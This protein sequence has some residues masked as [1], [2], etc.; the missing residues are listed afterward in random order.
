MGVAGGGLTRHHLSHKHHILSFSGEFSFPEE[1]WANVSNDA[2]YLL[3]KL[4]V[5]DPSKRFT[6]SEAMRS[7]WMV[8][9]ADKLKRISLLNTSQRLATFNARM[10]LRA[11]MIA[12]SAMTSIRMSVSKDIGDIVPLEIDSSDEEENIIDKET[13][14]DDTKGDSCGNK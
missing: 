7:S 4:L 10:K 14:D 8:E 11:A 1:S 12:V 5:T 2:K 13:A 6:S 3:R 9:P